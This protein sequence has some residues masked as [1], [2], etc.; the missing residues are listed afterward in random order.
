[1]SPYSTGFPP[2]GQ[3]TYPAWL[4]DIYQVIDHLLPEV[5]DVIG[6]LILTLSKNVPSNRTF[7]HLK[8]SMRVCMFSKHLCGIPYYWGKNIE[9]TGFIFRVGKKAWPDGLDTFLSLGKPPI[10]ITM[11]TAVGP[12]LAAKFYEPFIKAAK[13]LN[14]RLVILT[15]NLTSDL[16]LYFAHENH[17]FLANEAQNSRLFP[18]CC[19]VVHH[20]GIGTLAEAIRAQKPSLIV[21]YAYDQPFNAFHAEQHDVGQH[22]LIQDCDEETI[23]SYFVSLL[24]DERYKRGLGAFAAKIYDENGLKTACDAVETLRRVP[25]RKL[26]LTDAN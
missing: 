21:P 11:G 17:V 14:K 10:A 24:E 3:M 9:V 5:R 4:P 22:L 2:K 1:M 6:G 20:G 12:T 23:K 25:C 16:K 13:T 18:Q 8:K 7:P 26:Q 19:L 15:G